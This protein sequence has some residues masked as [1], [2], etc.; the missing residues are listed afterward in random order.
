MFSWSDWIVDCRFINHMAGHFLMVQH[1]SRRPLT[2][3]P[4]RIDVPFLLLLIFTLIHHT[5]P[6]SRS[7]RQTSSHRRLSSSSIHRSSSW[8]RETIGCG[9][10]GWFG[11]ITRCRGFTV[12]CRLEME[13][14]RWDGWIYW[15]GDSTDCECGR[16][17]AGWRAKDRC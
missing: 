11:S 3:R 16:Y 12:F 1:L 5:S 8:R 17:R 2:N 15:I 6:R 13:Y 9:D 14:G 4:S 10:V 7:S